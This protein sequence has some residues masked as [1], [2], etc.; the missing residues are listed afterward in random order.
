[1]KVWAK[2]INAGKILVIISAVFFLTSCSSVIPEVAI[3]EDNTI[4]TDNLVSEIESKANIDSIYLDVPYQKYAGTNWCLPASGSMALNFFGLNVSQQELAK[5]II[6]PD[7]L[8]DIYKMVKFARDLGFEATF[9]VLTM[10]EIEKYLSNN[11]PLIAIQEYK[12]TNTL[13]HA[14][15]VIGF[16]SNK[17]E[18][19]SNDPT[20]GQNYTMSYDEFMGLNLTSNPE[21]CMTIVI[22]PDYV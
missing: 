18:I 2:L 9:T 20:I 15:V 19:I 11:I 16:D 5:K 21:Y 6:K 3:E 17:Q 1:M 10:E 7:G 8:G 12:E 14:R 13:A 22:S 4:P